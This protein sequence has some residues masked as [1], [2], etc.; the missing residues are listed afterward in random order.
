MHRKFENIC[1]LDDTYH[2][3]LSIWV[4]LDFKTL[5]KTI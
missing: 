3:I 5:T 2:T 1:N 4:L